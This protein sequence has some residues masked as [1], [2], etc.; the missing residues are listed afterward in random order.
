QDG[1]WQHDYPTN[2]IATIDARKRTITL[3][4]MLGEGHAIIKGL[5]NNLPGTTLFSQQDMGHTSIWF[6]I[7]SWW[8]LSM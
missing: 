4:T 7:N 6:W 5:A 8:F 1:V 3:N 2:M